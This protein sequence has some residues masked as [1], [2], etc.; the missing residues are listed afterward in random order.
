MMVAGLGSV[1]QLHQDGKLRVIAIA[2][3]QRTVIAPDIPTA[4]E[5]GYPGV[6][7]TSTFALLAP[8]GTP[9]SIVDKLSE[10]VGRVM[11]DNAFQKELRSASVAPVI[12]STPAGTRQFLANEVSKWATLVRSAGLKLQP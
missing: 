7:A 8:L 10:A 6:V 9:S 1:Y 11:A 12:G 2:D 3:E 4:K 5:A